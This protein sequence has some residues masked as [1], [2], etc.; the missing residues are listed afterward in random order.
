MFI[1]YFHI[2]YWLDNWNFDVQ[3]YEILIGKKKELK[4]LLK[5]EKKKEQMKEK[6]RKKKTIFEEISVVMHSIKNSF[7]VLLR[8]ALI[9]VFSFE[10]VLLG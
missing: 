9:V 6:S 4:E 8:L 3:Q 1:H 5:T 10:Y 7:I 2:V